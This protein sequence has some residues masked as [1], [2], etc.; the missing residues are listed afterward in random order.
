MRK[1]RSLDAK[2]FEDLYRKDPDPWCFGTSAYEACKY[3][4][5]IAA[6]G[7][8]PVRRGLELG[9]AIGVLTR[10]LAPKCGRLVA[11]ELSRT[12]LEQARLRCIDLT[13]ID[14]ILARRLTDGFEGMFD[15]I[16]LSE[17]VYYWDDGDLAEM[18]RAVCEHLVAG[19]RLV[20]VHWLGETDYPHSADEAIARFA[21]AM[22]HTF[23]VV[24][25]TR[26]DDYRL[27]VWKLGQD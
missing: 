20:L 4:H 17:V 27:D 15:L 7:D 23:G 11:T 2:F 25:A 1:L 3:V 14:F 13:N 22:R 9:C 19:G 24:T 16:V 18:A 10:K 5:T 6:L 26:N 12:A 21:H 8:E